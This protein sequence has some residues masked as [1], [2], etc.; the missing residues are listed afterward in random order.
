MRLKRPGFVVGVGAL[1]VLGALTAGSHSGNAGVAANLA[2]SGDAPTN[3]V[4]VVARR[5]GD[6]HGRDRDAD[7]SAFC[8]GHIGGGP[9]NQRRRMTTYFSKEVLL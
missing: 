1:A 7:N 4:F 5:F 8:N 2:G 9:R 6:E 3:T